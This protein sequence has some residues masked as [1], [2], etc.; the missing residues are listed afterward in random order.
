MKIIKMRL[1]VLG[2]CFGLML[3][4][5][6]INAL[7]AGGEQ[8]EDGINVT[9][10]YDNYIHTEGTKADWGFACLI[11]GTEKTIL[12]DTG[13]KPDIL[14]HNI[15]KLNID[16]NKVEQIVI[17]HE[18]GDHFGGLFSFLEK[19]SDAPIYIPASF[20]DTFVKRT[21]K[22]GG[23][24]IKVTEPVEL[25]KNV[26]LTGEMGTEIIEH[27][28]I[29][30]TSKG[31]VVI[32]GCAH[33]GVTKIVNKAR[34]ILNKDVYF[35]FGGFHLMQKSQAQVQAIIKQFEAAGVVKCGATHCT[36]DK[37]I[38]WFKEA[39]GD[40]YVSMGVGKIIKIVI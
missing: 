16:I 22:A 4:T 28:L 20:S 38:E 2:I 19:K 33:P 30:D 29:F 3:G 27:S 15:K 26:Y 23:K 17:S 39:Y 14:W 31:L 13:T 37:Q 32:T 18:H 5:V 6:N 21:E 7:E 10:L 11:E 40:D 1:I 35:V 8:A 9:I 36:G 34:E 12:F 24:V 25:C